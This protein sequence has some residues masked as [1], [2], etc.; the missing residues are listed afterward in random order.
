MF[1]CRWHFGVLGRASHQLGSRCC[2]VVPGYWRVVVVVGLYLC[3][4][5]VLSGVWLSGGFGGHVDQDAHILYTLSAL[6]VLVMYDALNRVDIDAVSRCTFERDASAVPTCMRSR[7]YPTG[8]VVCAT[9]CFV[10][11]PLTSSRCFTAAFV[12]HIVLFFCFA[13][14][15]FAAHSL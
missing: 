4:T 14:R 9:W 6:Q 13:L 15:R 8:G 10:C 1:C 11:N 12:L 2:H 3:C 7:V 5:F